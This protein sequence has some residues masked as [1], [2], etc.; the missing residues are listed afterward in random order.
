MLFKLLKKCD[1]RHNRKSA[2]NSD[3]YPFE[4]NQKRI[5]DRFK[6]AISL[7][8]DVLK[9][10]NRLQSDRQPLQLQSVL[11]AEKEDFDRIVADDPS[12]YQGEFFRRLVEEAIEDYHNE[13]TGE[14]NS[15][16]TD[17]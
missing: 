3:H 16:Q 15:V 11:E 6:R 4:T 7:A 14:C 17:G 13:R 1:E 12:F 8:D 2:I 5:E 9:L 10:V